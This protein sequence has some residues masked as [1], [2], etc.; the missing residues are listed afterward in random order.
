MISIFKKKDKYD[1]G[2]YIQA[3]TEFG[4]FGVDGVS[5]DVYRIR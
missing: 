3:D 2:W 1:I 4:I 5:G